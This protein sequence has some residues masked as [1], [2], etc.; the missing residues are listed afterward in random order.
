[1]KAKLFTDGGSRGNPGHAGIGAIIKANKDYTY[2]AYIGKTTNNVAEYKA[3]ILG[4]E[5]ALENDFLELE[6]F[7]DS[8]LLVKQVLGIYRVKQEHLIPLFKKIKEL[9]ARFNSF[10]ISHIRREKNKEADSLVNLALD[11]YLQ[12]EA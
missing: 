4:L 5:K 3:L 12:N 8:E 7:C 9:L 2:N 11:N 10:A 6:I 1:M